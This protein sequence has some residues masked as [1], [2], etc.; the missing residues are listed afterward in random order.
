MNRMGAP[1]IIVH[2]L[3]QA[4]AA[5]KVA[6]ELAV[7][8]TLISAPGAAA[9]LGA[10]VFRD[11]I[12]GASRCHPG[13]SHKAVLDCGDDP[14][15]VLGALRHGIKAVR[16]DVGADVGARLADIAAQRGAIILTDETP[17]LDLIDSSDPL[18]ACRAWLAAADQR[19]D[20]L[21]PR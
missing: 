1:R 16:V 17:A 5:L 18:A 2:N 12:N 20:S 13:V 4:K 7:A 19:P 11:M 10:A 6:G 9:Y 21:K 8:V 15:L 3:E 14:G